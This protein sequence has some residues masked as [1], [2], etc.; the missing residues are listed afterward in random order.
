MNFSKT[1][2]Y[3]FRILSYMAKD[4]ERLYTT[5]D[6][7]EDLKIPFRYL[8]KLMTI[9][10]NNSLLVS[11]KG[12]NGGYRLSKRSGKIRLSDIVKVTGDSQTVSKCFF[13]FQDCPLT[14]KCAMH[15]RWIRVTE[16]I[17]DIL[18][19]T[20]LADLQESKPQHIF[21]KISKNLT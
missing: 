10:S 14:E 2:E 6:L 11:F 3:S 9:L 17:H 15:E 19:S 12:K 4:E 16:H 13:G 8:R 21:K 18:N 1:T 7:Y 20:T 5:T